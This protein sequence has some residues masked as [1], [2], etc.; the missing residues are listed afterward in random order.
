MCQLEME[1]K[2]ISLNGMAAKPSSKENLP[3][4]QILT[5]FQ[6]MVPHGFK[7]T[8]RDCEIPMMFLMSK[9]TWSEHT[10]LRRQI[11]R[12]RIGNYT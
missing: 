9:E 4:K 7:L 8:G 2:P 5:A 10:S 1:I 12:W 11:L 6:K 3:V